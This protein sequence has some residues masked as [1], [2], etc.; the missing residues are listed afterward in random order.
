MNDPIP[1][2]VC[3]PL[4]CLFT[5]IGVGMSIW[6]LHNVL[7]GVSNDVPAERD[8]GER[9]MKAGGNLAI[10]ACY[11]RNGITPPTEI[12]EAMVTR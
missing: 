5:A 3:I 12:I 4:A 11:I 8:L 9:Q 1:R 6:G 2:E 10:L 7:K